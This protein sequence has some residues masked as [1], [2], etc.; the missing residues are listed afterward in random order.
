MRE[1]AGYRVLRRLGEGGMGS[2]FLAESPEGQRVAVKVIHA[3]LLDREEFRERFRREVARAKTVPPFCTAEVIAADP[4]HDP[5]YLVIEYVDGPT[6]FEVLQEHG[7]LRGARLHSL[8][9]GVATA[10]T[11]IHGAGVIHRDLKPGNVLISAGSIKVIDFGIARE[12]GSNTGNL[13]TGSQVIGTVPYLSPERLGGAKQITPAADVFAWAGVITFAA[14][15]RTPF[16]GETPADTAI[17][18]LSD[19]P[20]LSG[21]PEELKGVV[22]RAL[23]KDPERRPTARELLDLLLHVAPTAPRSAVPEETTQ[24]MRRP[25]WRGL[26]LGLATGGLSV[27]LLVT[28]AAISLSNRP[29]TPTASDT[30]TSA[31]A[32]A[33]PT[34]SPTPSATPS[35]TQTPTPT[36]EASPSA[37]QSGSALRLIIDDPLTKAKPDDGWIATEDKTRGKC[38]IGPAGLTATL[39]PNGSVYR[40]TGRWDQTT[41]FDAQVEVKTTGNS[42][43]AIWFRFQTIGSDSPGAPQPNGGYALQLCDRTAYFI[44]HNTVYQTLRT[45]PLHT[46]VAE[47]SAQIRITARGK[48]FNFYQDGR[49]IG[50][51]D[52]ATFLIGRIALG[53]FQRNGDV[54]GSNHSVTFKNLVVYGTSL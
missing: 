44:K 2:V 29:G 14:T 25:K 5:P 38:T 18:I 31:S 1:I 8:A 43:A 27:A 17:S 23:D 53:T 49:V 48:E 20:D 32:G 34:T 24:P 3:H 47:R 45:L 28:A 35:P 22:A 52:D 15:G 36:P 11:A 9:V 54:V 7:P 46:S 16:T 37:G 39:Q 41:D 6:L 19:P 40:C 21:V 10:L 33:N 13:T 12:I 51:A 4:D 30:S 26:R 50:T 42:C